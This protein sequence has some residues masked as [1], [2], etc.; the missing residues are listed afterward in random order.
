MNTETNLTLDN[1]TKICV[2]ITSKS[3]YILKECNCIFLYPI[4]ANYPVFENYL[5]IN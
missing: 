4:D 5:N 3:A 1:N 2:N